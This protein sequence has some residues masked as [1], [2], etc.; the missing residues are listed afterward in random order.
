M[1]TEL[2]IRAQIDTENVKALLL[3]NGGGAV[4]LLAFLPYVLPRAE[5]V[6]LTQKII[7]ALLIYQIGLFLAVLHNHLRRKCSI[8]Y[9]RHGYKPPPCKLFGRP[10]KE[11]CVCHVSWSCMWGSALAFMAAGLCVF[12]GGLQVIGTL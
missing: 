3:I 8:E 5:Y 11:P 6:L 2:E 9:Q 4:A 7:W 10:L 12:Y 1:A